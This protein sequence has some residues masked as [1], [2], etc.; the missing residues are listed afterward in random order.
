[1]G[2]DRGRDG[3]A[4][5]RPDGKGPVAG[6]GR[7]GVAVKRSAVVRV[8]DWIVQRALRVVWESLG[9]DRVTCS[10]TGLEHIP[11]S[12]PAVLAMRHHHHL[13]DGVSLFRLMPRT[14]H[15]LVTLDWVRTPRERWG[16]T[17][18]TRWSRW[19][20]VLRADAVRRA[21]EAGNFMFRPDDVSRYG[22]AAIRLA[23]DVLAEG[24]IL[25]VFPEG[26]PNVD[27]NF[28]PKTGL[29]DFLRFHDGF[30]ILA[31]Q[32]ERRLG[33]PVPIIP[34]GVTHEPGPP[35]HSRIHF[36]APLRCEDFESRADLVREVERRVIQLS[37][38]GIDTRG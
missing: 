11:P 35:W 4:V 21:N 3:A 19:P 34:A 30:A 27:P 31:A 29:D 10:A 25:V 13:F 5:K 1:V 12:G 17:L 32:A 20:L 23:L 26:Y 38:P 28:T 15:A 18:L 7:R 33:L 16:M 37:S 36:G 14:F 9:G 24:R 6:R 22:R 2:A 8:H